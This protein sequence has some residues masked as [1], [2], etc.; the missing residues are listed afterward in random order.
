MTIETIAGE[1]RKM[2]M[3]YKERDPERLCREMGIL[4]KRIPMGKGEKDCKGFFIVKCRIR[5]IILNADLPLRRQR[6]VLSHELGHAV[7]HCRYSELRTFHDFELFDETSAFEYEANIFAAEFLL[8]D[9]NVLELLNEDIS[10]FNAA[11]M[12]RVPPELLDFKFRVLKRKGYALN[13]P[14]CAQSDFMKHI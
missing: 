9:E 8:D 10:F 12:L 7:L 11:R 2:K 1:V 13:S 3:Q 4:V 5:M 6:I 14:I